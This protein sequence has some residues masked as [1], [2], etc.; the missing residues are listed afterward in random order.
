MKRPG[1]N[2]QSYASHCVG[3]PACTWA[4]H[5]ASYNIAYKTVPSDQEKAH[6]CACHA[7]MSAWA[8]GR[9]MRQRLVPLHFIWSGRVLARVLQPLVPLWR[10]LQRVVSAI[11]C[12]NIPPLHHVAVNV[13]LPPPAAPKLKDI[14]RWEWH[15][16]GYLSFILHNPSHRPDVGVA[17]H[18]AANN[19][20]AL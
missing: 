12:L 13:L 10:Y 20:L 8:C 6:A 19:L 1:A 18:I 3:G 4:S 9:G 17:M 5:S 15:V 16:T 2:C 14:S 11:R 7:R